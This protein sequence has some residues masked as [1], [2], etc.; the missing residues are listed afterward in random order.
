LDRIKLHLAAAIK[1]SFISSSLS[2]DVT[3]IVAQEKTIAQI[4]KI[5]VKVKR[6]EWLDLK[7]LEFAR[8]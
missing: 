7:E 5:K 2:A 8:A 1:Q 4:V 6:N 3:A